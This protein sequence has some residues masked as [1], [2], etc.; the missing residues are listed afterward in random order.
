MISNSSAGSFMG[1]GC[2]IFVLSPFCCI[3]DLGFGNHS[4][5]GHMLDQNFSIPFSLSLSESL[6]HYPL[7]FHIG[8]VVLS[9]LLEMEINFFMV[10]IK[11]YSFILLQF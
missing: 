3:W 10:H 5:R 8:R 2:F 7:S 9:I 4:S 6:L 11:F 1:F